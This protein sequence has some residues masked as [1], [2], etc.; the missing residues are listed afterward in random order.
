LPVSHGDY[1][2]DWETLKWVLVD[3]AY[4]TDYAGAVVLDI[5]AHKG[6]FGAFALERG[7]RTVI[8]FEPE[9]RNFELLERCAASYREQGADRRQ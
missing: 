9:S 8:S 3:E 6:Y 1:P 7:A 5:G 4:P 2:I